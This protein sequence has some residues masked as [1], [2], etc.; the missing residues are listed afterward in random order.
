MEKKVEL[1]MPDG[2]KVRVMEHQVHDAVTKFGATRNKKELKEV[3]KELLR[4]PEKKVDPL[5]QMKIEPAT[6]PD[7]PV[8]AVPM[9]KTPVRSKSKK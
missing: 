9:R 6:E 5:P 4:I 2:R 8:T 7:Y 1:T 3:P